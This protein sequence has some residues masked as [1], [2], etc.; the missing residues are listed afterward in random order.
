V[1]ISSLVAKSSAIELPDEKSIRVLKAMAQRVAAWENK[2][3][4]S[5]TLVPGESKPFNVES[6]KGLASIGVDIPVCIPLEQRLTTIIED[7]GCRHCLCGGPSDGRFMVGCDHCDV[8]FHGHC[9]R[10]SATDDLTDWKCPCCT[11]TPVES[12][13]LELEK[14][15]DKY[16]D[17]GAE[18][19]SEDMD[20]SRHSHVDVSSKAPNPENLWPPFGLFGSETAQEAMGKELAAIPD[21]VESQHQPALVVIDR[22]MKQEPAVSFPPR[23]PG[24]SFDAAT[25]NV[26][27]SD[28]SNHSAAAGLVSGNTGAIGF[29]STAVLGF[30][31]RVISCSSSEVTSLGFG[32]QSSAASTMTGLSIGS[33]TTGSTT[34]SREMGST[35]ASVRL[36]VLAAA[37]T[38]CPLVSVGT[39]M[40]AN[41]PANS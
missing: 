26:G 11:G 41:V 32:S 35:A 25:L 18:G 38:Q 8:W 3:L 36:P 12:I 20:S 28:K 40:E 17:A 16:T 31:S 19:D 4:K 13:E 37:P 24:S 23:P 30:G 6:L 14:F 22:P 1:E 15:H 34:S 39:A 2:V 7:G 27:T 29:G 5:L 21:G 33:S 9:V 10:V